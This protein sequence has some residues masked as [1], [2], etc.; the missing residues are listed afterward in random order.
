MA[1]PWIRLDTGLPDNPK[2][3]HLIDAKQHRAINVY[4][5]SL[6]YCGRHMLDGYI[7]NTALKLIHGTPSDAQTLID[8]GLWHQATGGWHINDWAD[9]QPSSDE[10]K[11]R[12]ERAQANAAKRWN[13]AT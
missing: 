10:A 8:I 6:A 13:K 9:Y 11:A 5:F 4:V 1:L 12:R 3:L 2:I 7:P